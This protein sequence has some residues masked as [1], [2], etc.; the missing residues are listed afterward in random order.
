M[1]DIITQKSNHVPIV[2]DNQPPVQFVPVPPQ[3]RP[4][5]TAPKDGTRILVY[6]PDSDNV[7]SVY[8]DDQFTYRFDEAKAEADLKY[9]G[10]HEGAWTDDA[11][12]SF[13]YEEK[14]SYKPT[15]WMP[16]PEPPP[17]QREGK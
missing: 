15:H 16:L 4:I 5:E 17:P 6:V 14:C 1:N 2:S 10:E 8:W 9:E 11:V 12:E 13:V 7:L 3:W